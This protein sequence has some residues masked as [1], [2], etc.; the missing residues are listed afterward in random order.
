[1]PGGP[2]AHI[3]FLVRDL[4]QAVED[5]KTILGEL[6]PAQLEQPIVMVERWEAGEDVMSS[7]TFVNPGGS[8]IQLLCPLNDG[9]LGRRLAKHGEHVHH[10]VLHVPRP[11]RRGRAPRGEGD[12]ADE[13]GAP[14][15]P[16]APVAALDVHLEGELPRRPRR[17]GLSVPAGGRGVGAGR[18][19]AGRRLV[20][21][22]PEALPS[23][24][25]DRAGTVRLVVILGGLA[26]FAPL[27]FDMYLPAFP[28]LAT[29]FGT[30]ASAIQLTLTSC[31]VGVAVGQLVFGSLSD[32]RGR[33]GPLLVGLVV[34]TVAS[35]LCALAPD[36]LD[37]RRSPLR[38][39]LRRR[40]RGR[41]VARG[42]PRPA[43]R[44]GRGALLLLA[45]ARERPRAGPRPVDRQRRAR[46]HDLGGD[47]P[48]AR[49]DG[50]PARRRRRARAPRDAPTR[51][52]AG[53]G[54][55]PRARGL[56]RA[57]PR[58]VVRRPRARARARGERGLRLH[59]G[60]VVRAPGRLRP[61]AAR[62]RRS[63]SASTGSAS[64]SAASST[65]SCSA[66]RSRGASCS[67]ASARA[68][69]RASASSPRSRRTRRSASCSR[70]SSSG[71]RRSAS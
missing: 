71:S 67:R 27:S 60:V 56:R 3:C 33:R 44:H 18:G 17:A 19:R 36:A 53:G 50:R 26:A 14:E 31:L 25:R 46:G 35:A 63:S 59:R 41:R 55:A 58:P 11:A 1:M 24:A 39:G 32:A 40:G 68:P 38:A 65:G 12:R 62:V 10:V 51:A 9:P 70:R 29:D 30:S 57:A 45:D 28:E 54:A 22:H 69:S 6:D 15:R 66:G 42:R 2:L 49:G 13:H 61:V 4:D 48:R 43:L 23:V 37:A 64:S 16:R 8:E 52:P 47:L 7:A 34:Y 21:G 5:W 20:V